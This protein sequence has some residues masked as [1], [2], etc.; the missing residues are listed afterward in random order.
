MINRQ[1]QLDQR[2]FSLIELMIVVAIIGILAAIAVPNFQRFQAKSRQSE[3]KS[4]LAALYTSEKA[5]MSEWQTYFQDFA[6]IGFRPEGQLRYDIGWSADTGIQTP[7]TYTGPLGGAA[8]VVVN[9][10]GA[11]SPVWFNLV[12]ALACGVIGG[13]VLN[14]ALINPSPS[15]YAPTAPAGAL[16]A[17]T[18]TASANGDID[19][20]ANGDEW[21]IDENKAFQNTVNDID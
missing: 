21:T 19:A 6:S 8:G 16:T 9:Q 1:H 7:A 18:F 17:T 5:F 11:A 13:P 15:G 3:A 12:G 4:N 10:N 14:C 20:D 2:G